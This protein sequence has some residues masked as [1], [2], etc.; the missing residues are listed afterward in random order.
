MSNESQEY[1]GQVKILEKL[2]EDINKIIRDTEEFGIIYKDEIDK[3]ENR[4]M[5]LNYVSPLRTKGYPS[6]KEKIQ[7]SIEELI[8][9][10][11]SL[12]I[13]IELLRDLAQISSTIEND[14]I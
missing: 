6:Y 4:G 12:E 8:R 5:M 1:L 14:L 3:T 9:M 13:F 7:R 2:I 10:R 11:S